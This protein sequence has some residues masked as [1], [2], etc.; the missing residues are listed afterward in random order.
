M[1]GD[2][3]IVANQLAGDFV[4]PADP[5]EKLVFLAGGIGVTPFRSMLQYLLDTGQRRPIVLVYANMNVDDI[6]YRDVFDKAQRVLGIAVIYT[7][8]DA[9]NLPASWKGRVGRLSPE[10]IRAVVPDYRDCTY[11]IS[12]PNQMVD[13]FQGLLRDLGIK[14]ARIKTDFFPGFT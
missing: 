12:G 10:L 7:L 9:R 6:L 1:D 14:A 13:S 4:L 2:T 8:T 5:N 3:E 11:Y